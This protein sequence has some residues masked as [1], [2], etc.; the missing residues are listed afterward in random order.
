MGAPSISK[1]SVMAQLSDSPS[2]FR[3]SAL[4]ADEKVRAEANFTP[5]VAQ[6]LVAEGRFEVTADSLELVELFQN[7]ARRVGELLRRPVVAYA[8][9]EVVVITFDPDRQDP[10][11]LERLSL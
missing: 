2:A 5:Y 10:A 6:A 7:V 8:N 3:R 11:A 4:S 9:G 1:G